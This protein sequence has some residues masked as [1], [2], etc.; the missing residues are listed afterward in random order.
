LLVW[1]FTFLSKMSDSSIGKTEDVVVE[2]ALAESDGI[3]PVPL[4]IPDS[5]S[6]VQ[7]DLTIKQQE[8][9]DKEVMTKS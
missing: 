6:I 1:P 3:L 4:S 8:A 9:I 5:K 7:D 2:E